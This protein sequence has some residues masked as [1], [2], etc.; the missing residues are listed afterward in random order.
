M[1]KIESNHLETTE[2]YTMNKLEIKRPFLS[3]IFKSRYFF[4]VQHSFFPLAYNFSGT[5]NL[6]ENFV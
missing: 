5:V 1:V 3:H 6:K 4:F 2:K